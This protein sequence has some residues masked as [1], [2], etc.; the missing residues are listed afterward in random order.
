L[1]RVKIRRNG[2]ENIL[3]ENNSGC[4]FCSGGGYHGQS[5]LVPAI[6]KQ[7]NRIAGPSKP[8]TDTA[9]PAKAECRRIVSNGLAS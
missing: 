2:Y 6:G 5:F 9:S 7:H 3:V 8:T 4:D 1:F